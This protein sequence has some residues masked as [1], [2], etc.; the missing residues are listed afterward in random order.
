MAHGPA[1]PVMV[2]W[3]FQHE[4][5]EKQFL[6]RHL[7]NL[8]TRYLKEHATFLREQ[9]FDASAQMMRDLAAEIAQTVDHQ[10]KALTEIMSIGSEGEA[11]GN[12]V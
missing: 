12:K 8:A 1:F 9:K 4:R 6:F 2:C 7:V 11:V 10:I 3:E 5:T